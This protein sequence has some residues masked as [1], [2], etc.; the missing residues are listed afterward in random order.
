V[1]G[2]DLHDVEAEFLATA[3]KVYPAPGACDGLP[4]VAW[5]G[6]AWSI[7]TEVDCSASNVFGPTDPGY[8]SY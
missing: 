3:P 6:G 5:E 4:E 8:Y 2:E 7:D 1:L